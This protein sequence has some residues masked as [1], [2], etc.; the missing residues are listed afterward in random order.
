MLA[1]LILSF[2]VAADATAVAIAAAVRGMTLA[3][4][5]AMACCF[6]VAQAGM[7]GIGWAGGAAVGGLWSAWN[8]W[9]ALALLS[10][11]GLKMIHEAFSKEEERAPAAAG[12]LTLL[13]LSIATS[14]DALAV[15]VSLP[16]LRVA[17]PI[18]LASIGLVTLVLSAA[19]AAFG[20]F[21]GE[22]FGR[23]I[24]VAGG[25]GLIAIGLR[26]VFEHT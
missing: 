6:G 11:V 18:A 1:L 4:G 13:V 19:G 16:A 26:I 23:V 5:L 8:H 12:F 24:E 20:R 17:A 22:R 25:V 15:G 10:F 9:I 2:G 21:L 14:L 3:R 7:A